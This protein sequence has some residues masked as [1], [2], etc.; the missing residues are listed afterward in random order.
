[1]HEARSADAC[2]LLCVHAQVL[3]R[4]QNV[5]LAWQS[6]VNSDAWHGAMQTMQMLVAHAAAAMHMCD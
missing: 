4:S 1:M 3:G 6:G 5:E 2:T